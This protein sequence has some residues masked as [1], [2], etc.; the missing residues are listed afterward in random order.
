MIR[1]DLGDQI[2]KIEDGPWPAFP[3]DLTSIALAVATQAR[4]TILIFEKMFENRLFFVDK[5][6]RMGAGSSSATRTARSSPARRSCTA[7][8]LESPDIRAGMA[9]II[10]ALCAEGTSTIGNISQIDR[11]YER[12]DERLR[13]LGASIERV[14]SRPCRLG[15][16]HLDGCRACREGSGERQGRA[17]QRRR[18]ERQHR[19]RRARLPDRRA[20]DDRR[21]SGS[22]SRSRPARSTRPSRRPDAASARGSPRSCAQPA[23]R[24]TALPGCRPTRH[25]PVRFSRSPNGPSSPR[26]STSPAG[27]GGLG[28]DVVAVFLRELAEG[29]GL[30]VHIRVLEGKDPQHVL[31]AIFKALGAAIGQAC[32][33]PEGGAMSKQVVRTEAA[34]APFQGA[35]Y[36]QAIVANGFVFVAGQLGLEPGSSERRRGRHRPADRAG[37]REPPGDPRGCGLVA[38]P[39][40]EDD[41]LP[42]QPRRLRRR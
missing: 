7:Q 31:R 21:G 29:A 41:R 42:Q 35:P 26:T 32:R 34:P 12:I 16:A 40:R 23:P 5:L 1:D 2:P 15:Y 28:S 22:R 36:N 6:V 30:N 33:N 9:M 38:R 11:G 20:R 3:A 10:A 27:V 39:G 17:R 4:G 25:S 13:A 8:R 37:V 19:A 14:S 24:E 18:I